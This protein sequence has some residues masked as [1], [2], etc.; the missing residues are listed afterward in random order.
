M[1]DTL[2]HADF[3]PHLNTK[4]RMLLPSAP[5]LE[6]ELVQADEFTASARQERFSLSFLAPNDAPVEQGVYE[7][8]HEQLGTGSLFLVPISRTEKGL[9]YE[10]VF[11]R[12]RKAEK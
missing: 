4:F 5:P 11:N 12:W 2:T 1:L 3:V 10:A 7:L 8:E 6:I 9:H